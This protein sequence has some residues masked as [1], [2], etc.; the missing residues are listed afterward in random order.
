MKRSFPRARPAALSLLGLLGF[1][2]LNEGCSPNHDVKPGA[3]V[4]TA[5]TIVENGTTNTSITADAI[6]CAATVKGGD[7]CLL[8]DVPASADGGDDGGL[9]GTAD[10]TCQTT[11]SDWCR[12]LG[13]ATMSPMGT[14]DCDPFS[15]MSMVY[16]TFDRL[17]DTKPLDPGDAA[18]QSRDDIVTLKATPAAPTP[19]T[20]ST[21]YSSTGDPNYFAFAGGPNLVGPSLTIQASPAMPAGTTVT[22]AL[23]KTKVLAKDG[24][25][26]FTGKGLIMDGTLTFNTAAFGV[27]IGVP[28]AP[29]PEA[30]ADAAADAATGV[31]G[32]ADAATEAGAEA[33]TDAATEAGA[34]AG[35][36]AGADGGVVADASGSEASTEAG[37]GEAGTTSDAA[38][39]ETATSDAA[40]ADAAPATPPTPGA[41]VPADMN[42]APL[43]LTFNNT[44][45]GD[46]TKMHV[47]ITEDG[48]PF[49]AFAVDTSM[50]PT[51]TITPTTAWAAGKTYVVTVD[52][53]TA[54]VV[55][56]T[57]KTPVAAAFVMAN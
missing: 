20:T 8:V 3:P 41:P 39:T 23:D 26:P 34:E 28:T 14:W 45:D 52:A 43:T 17:L 16:A 38:A 50:A 15:P 47:T 12:C 25:T 35:T 37:A 4:L 10:K 46:M 22:L 2:S 32:G 11:T 13:D 48:K 7:A 54:D 31:D 19:V 1:V 33:G 6:P 29:P 24:K 21:S 42:M 53:T 9:T 27:Q 30:G 40:V 51:L 44:I 55:G 36:D 5:L 56:D 49:T 18:T 57:L